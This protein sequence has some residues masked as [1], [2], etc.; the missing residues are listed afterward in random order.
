MI[1]VLK[2]NLIKVL[3]KI[4]ELVASRICSDAG[5]L[6]NLHFTY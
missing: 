5:W 1:D 2:L 4:S 3:K 6:Y